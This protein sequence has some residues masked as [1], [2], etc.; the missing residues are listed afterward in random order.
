MWLKRLK[1]YTLVNLTPLSN[2]IFFVFYEVFDVFSGYKKYFLE[3][4]SAFVTCSGEA[5]PIFYSCYVNFNC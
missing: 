2:N 3:K 5:S 1:F 4:T